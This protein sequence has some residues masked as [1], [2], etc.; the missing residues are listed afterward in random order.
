MPNDA[1]DMRGAVAV[2]NNVKSGEYT[3]VT[4][5]YQTLYG[6]ALHVM[7]ITLPAGQ[8]GFVGVSG[9]Y[10]GPND[11]PCS[12]LDSNSTD[13]RIALRPNSTITLTKVLNNYPNPNKLSI[14]IL[15]SP[16][17]QLVE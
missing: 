5:S 7:R 4:I 12:V 2:R 9:C 1:A 16:E 13:M 8:N 11:D 10:T 3:N 17:L 14:Q 6:T 15:T